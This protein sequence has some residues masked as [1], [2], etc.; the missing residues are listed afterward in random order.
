VATTS[1]LPASTILRTVWDDLGELSVAAAQS[2]HHRLCKRRLLRV[3]RR[4]DAPGASVR[5]A[6]ADSGG[7]TWL[8]VKAYF[9]TLLPF[10]LLVIS[11]VGLAWLGSAHDIR[12]GNGALA[13]DVFSGLL[14]FLIWT[15]C[16]IVS[17]QLFMRIGDRVKTGGPAAS[18][19]TGSS[20]GHFRISAGGRLVQLGGLEP[21][22]S[23]STDTA[24]ASPVLR[25]SRLSYENHSI[26]NEQVRR[27]PPYLRCNWRYV[28][29]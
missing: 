6:F 21:P 27:L 11:I 8:I 19:S 29:S 13:A 15:S 16:T 23:C 17:A 28:G 5:N 25:Q 26:I 4:V 14:G 20:A 1:S 12:S 2:V 10:I 3:D 7:H 22:T 18:E 24:G 9:V